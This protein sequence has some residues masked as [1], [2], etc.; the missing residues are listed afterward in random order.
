[1]Y[2]PFVR[3][4]QFELIA[5]RELAPTLAQAGVVSPIIEPVKAKTSSLEKSLMAL[6]AANV[7]FTLILN[8][9]VGELTGNYKRITQII[10][11]LS[12]YSNFQIG[13]NVQSP[14]RLNKAAA[15]LR[16]NGF[17]HIPITLVHNREMRE[18]SALEAFASEFNIRY[19]VIN[20]GEVGRRYRRNFSAATLVSL[21]DQFN[22]QEKNADYKELP[23][24]VFTDEHKYYEEE[25]FVGFSDFATIGSAFAEGGFLPYAVAIHLTFERSGVIDIHHFV[26]DTNDDNADTPGKFAEAL[27]HVISWLNANPHFSSTAIQEFRALHTD[28]HYPG[29]GSIK[30]LSLMHHVELVIHLMSR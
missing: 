8:P 5:L 2:M 30:K 6:A 27:E 11:S 26:S 22:E 15:Y 12:H 17:Q 10:S 23:V 7:N 4:K 21:E 9:R 28:A 18:I 16:E 29:L 20:F 13:I 19:N 3:G 1:M 24:E 25:G 14:D